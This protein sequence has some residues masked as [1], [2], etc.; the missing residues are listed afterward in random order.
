[1]PANPR[2]DPRSRTPEGT[3]K[4]FESFGEV[5]CP[6]LGAHLYR[7]LCGGI[8]RDPQLLAMAARAPAWQ[9][10]PNLL[11]A[12]VHLLL[13][14]GEEH[15]LRA[16][17]PA[18]SGVASPDPSGAFPAFRDLCLRHRSTIE[19]SSETRLTQTNVIQRTGAL[20]PA[21]ARVFECGGGRPLAVLEIGASAGLNL[22][23]PHAATP[24]AAGSSGSGS[25][26]LPDR[27]LRPPVARAWAGTPRCVSPREAA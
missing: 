24:T 4:L 12:S 8:A 15:P 10:P 26:T 23:W 27:P 21:F 16:W 18:L 2:P 1:M 17:Y 19:S 3:A 14:R 11:F 20:L 22:Q 25:R 9:P 6:Q 13:L 7:A 5:E